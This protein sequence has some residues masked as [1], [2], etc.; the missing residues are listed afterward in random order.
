[1]KGMTSINKVTLFSAFCLLFMASTAQAALG[2][3]R[4]SVVNFSNIINQYNP[5]STKFV[6]QNGILIPINN[7]TPVN[8]S[9]SFRDTMFFN[10]IFLPV[11]FDGRILPSNLNFYN[12]DSTSQTQWA[13][14]LLPRDKT[15]QSKIERNQWRKA[16]RQNF[17]TQNLSAVQ[18][19][20]FGFKNLPSI[21]D[22]ELVSP[23]ELKKE[24][25][26]RRNEINTTIN[27]Q[28]FIPRRIYWTKSGEHTLQANQN[29]FS[30]N[31][32]SGGV[33]NYSVSNYHKILLNYRKNKVSWNNTFEWKLNFQST[34][35]DSLHKISVNDDYLRIYSVIGIDAAQT[36]WSYSI[37]NEIKTSLF[38]MYGVNS[39][40]KSAALF[41]PFQVN[42]GIGMTYSLTKTSPAYK[43]R[44]LALT[45]DLSPFS[46]NY[47]YVADT[48]VDVTKFGVT[49]GKKAN[50]DLGSTYN[51]NLVYSYNRYA[52]LTSRWRYFTSYSKVVMESENKFD[53]AFT[54][55]LSSS[56]YLYMRY[57]DGV[58][59][60]NKSASLGYFQYKEFVG[61]GITY[62]W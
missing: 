57:D 11:V 50:L 60:A 56:L 61:F 24:I 62:K 34:P 7:W 27:V 26:G 18:Y 40:V 4:Q 59:V 17:Y 2:G 44:K 33:N 32:S 54:R 41:S 51:L 13:F 58:G 37:K 39:G 38:N 22:Q 47:V 45:L 8:S 21:E 10:P 30:D 15:F 28:K 23:K 52:T 31:W 14:H 36:K 3:K 5:D 25:V 16:V 55:L 48:G 1:M 46:L 43:F 9:L 6:R 29:Q 42:T 12:S 19:S 49:Q 35:A 53:F 20:I